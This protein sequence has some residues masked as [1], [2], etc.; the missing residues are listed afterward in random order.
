MSRHHGG[1]LF[2]P[3]AFAAAAVGGYF[4]WRHRQA[5]PKH[6][7]DQKTGA[8]PV[9]AKGAVDATG[10]GEVTLTKGAVYRVVFWANKKSPAPLNEILSKTDWTS[11]GMNATPLSDAEAATTSKPHS[12]LQ[13]ADQIASFAP[14]AGVLV[15]NGKT[16]TW[17][18][19]NPDVS[20]ATHVASI[21]PGKATAAVSG[22]NPL[23]ENGGVNYCPPY[24]SVKC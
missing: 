11:N 14:Y 3:L 18:L 8:L 20:G 4:W 2:A 1:G 10:D 19:A 5:T 21:T 7:K 15:W 22:Y 13:N 16:D 24:S 6:M 17:N 23:G 12:L 9:H